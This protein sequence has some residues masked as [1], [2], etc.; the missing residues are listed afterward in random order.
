MSSDLPLDSFNL[1]PHQAEA[2]SLSVLAKILRLTNPSVDIVL[3][4]PWPAMWSVGG[5]APGGQQPDGHQNSLPRH[6]LEV[7]PCSACL[8]TA[9]ELAT[10]S[11]RL[12]ASISPY[13]LTSCLYSSCTIPGAD[14]AT[15]CMEGPINHSE[16]FCI[17]HMSVPL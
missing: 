4:K 11:T 7:A 13:G 2:Y 12:I 6:V 1:H 10:P 9:C 14:L 8:I 5:G 15:D 3:Y 17:E 16:G